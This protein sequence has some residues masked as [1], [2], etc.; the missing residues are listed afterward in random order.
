MKGWRIR[1]FGDPEV[2]DLVEMEAPRP[3]ADDVVVRV[4]A[5]GVNRADLLQRQGFY[6]PPP[7]FD[8]YLPGLEYAGVVESVGSRVTL[9]KPGDRVMGIVAGGG[10]A[11]NVV[12]NARETVAVPSGMDLTDAGAIPE[13]FLT[14]Y[15][16][17]FLEGGLRRNELCVVRGA[18]SGVGLAAVQ[19]IAALGARSL[20]TSRSAERLQR[21]ADIGLDHSCVEGE[22]SL[23]DAVKA[24]GDRSGAAV[25]VDFVG[26]D[27][28]ADG[29]AALREEG[30]LVLVGLMAGRQANIDLGRVLMRRLRL[31]AMTMRSLP[32]ERRI[33]L[34]REFESIVLPLFDQGALRPVLDRVLP[35]AEAPE[36]HRRMA[37]GTHCGKIVL[38]LEG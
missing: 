10:Y 13:A 21:V 37:G 9:R 32:L 26:G 11:Q 22:G 3:G 35:F 25:V 18:T 27:G 12:V 17:V 2:L 4:A 23:R 20:G 1:E 31:Q 30:T 29:L 36:A 16:A 14:A 6:P 33:S 8:P 7:G 5:A 34:A 28:V 15:R 38:T 24:A 19:L